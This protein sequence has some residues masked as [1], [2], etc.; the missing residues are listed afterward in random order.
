MIAI[1][2]KHQ[3]V[4]H[5]LMGDGLMASFGTPYPDN[6]HADSGFHASKEIFDFLAS[7]R[8]FGKSDIEVFIRIGLHSGTVISGNVGNENRKQFTISGTPI[9]IAARLEQLNKKYK[10]RFLTTKELVDRM[11][12]DNFNFID[13]GEVQVKGI[14][15][16]INVLEIE[17]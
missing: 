2:N 8:K 11:T 12:F 9:I 16:K 3:G 13:H 4:V 5:Q 1:V 17:L 14:D 7:N 10:S 6:S 15:E